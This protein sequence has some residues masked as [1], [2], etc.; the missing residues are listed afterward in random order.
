MGSLGSRLRRAVGP[1]EET[2]LAEPGG[3]GNL[4]PDGHEV[5]TPFGPCFVIETRY[6]LGD[7]HGSRRLGGWF[8]RE[9]PWAAVLTGDGKL[10]GQRPD[11]ALFFDI[12]STGLDHGAG[13][14]AF[15]VGLGRRQGDGFVVRQLLLRSPT[16]EQA[17]L[18]LVTEAIEQSPMLVSFNGKSFDLTVLASRLV[19]QRFRRASESGWKLRPHLDLLHLS[20][21]LYRGHLAN[22]RL[23][24][25]EEEL[26][27]VERIDDV[28]GSLVPSLYFHFLQTGNTEP[29]A[30]V[31]KHNL[32]DVL[33]MVTLADRL[34]EDADLGARPG[35][36]RHV[37][38]NLGRLLLRRKRPASALTLL[39]PH[40]HGDP[41]P[42][43][44]HL[45]SIAARR[46]GEGATQRRALEE[47]IR[48]RPGDVPGLNALA[49]LDARGSHDLERALGWAT[50]A[51]G[52]QPTEATERRLFRIRR[53]LLHWRHGSRGQR[54][55][56][57]RRGPSPG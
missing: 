5:E 50:R 25:L 46:C 54:K 31:V 22:T 32:I 24:T 6:D 33:S 8:D 30:R 49:I 38:E 48:R 18:H 10:E 13:N 21:N 45:L 1:V 43:M 23:G 17:L 37:T 28:P 11:D 19:L 2:P 14:I 16:E 15:L 9:L 52:L 42:E 20:R 55:S 4:L 53:R 29:L 39:R 44:L 57:H 3:Q 12:E 51:H 35:R 47:L 36:P 26:L 41:S 34:L 7:R 40:L 27:G 56:N